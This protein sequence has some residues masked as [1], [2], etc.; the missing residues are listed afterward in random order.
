MFGSA[1]LLNFL[2]HNHVTSRRGHDYFDM[3][4]RDDCADGCAGD[5]SITGRRND[6]L[7]EAVSAKV[8]PIVA[9]CIHSITVAT[10]DQYEAINLFKRLP[11]AVQRFNAVAFRANF[12]TAAELDSFT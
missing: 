7:F 1:E 2:R 11:V 12:I 4:Q 9:P 8:A 10:G 5:R 3:N 6:R